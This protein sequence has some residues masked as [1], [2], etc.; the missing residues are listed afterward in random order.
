MTAWQWWQWWG[1]GH[2]SQDSGHWTLDTDYCSAAFPRHHWSWPSPACSG[3]ASKPYHTT[4][5][6]QGGS[7][8]SQS[9]SQPLIVG[10][11]LTLHYDICGHSISHHC[12]QCPLCCRRHRPVTKP[13]HV[14]GCRD[15]SLPEYR[16]VSNLGVEVSCGQKFVNNFQHS[17]SGLRCRS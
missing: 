15:G 11:T 17:M 14:G 6:P 1:V 3:P 4:A 2:W 7:C 12:H 5:L 8:S 13:H 16:R 9:H 10:R